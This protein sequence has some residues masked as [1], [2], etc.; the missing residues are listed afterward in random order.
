MGREHLAYPAPIPG[1]QRVDMMKILG[2]SLTST[3]S[4]NA[5]I[6]IALRQAAQSMYALSVL[7]SHGL[8][9]EALWDV[10]HTRAT[11]QARMMYAS[12][13]WWG[14]ADMGH[15]QR[16]QNFIFKLQR[17]G[18]LPRDS[19]SFEDMCGAADEVLFASVLSNEYHV[20]A[21]LLPPVK[22][23]PYQLRLRAHNRSLPVSDN[24]MPKNFVTRMLYKD[25]F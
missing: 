19:P 5:H 23:T 4:F 10:T 16:L 7:R 3:F 9:G 1:I 20:L 24:L 22:E 6:D 11:T 21:Q 15:R 14:Y 18:F 17:L 8:T 25:S 13:A 2:V 12:P